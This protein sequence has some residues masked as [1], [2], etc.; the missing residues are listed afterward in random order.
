M[1]SKLTNPKKTQKKL[2]KYALKQI[3]GTNLNSYCD[4][5]L[6]DECPEINPKMY[7]A[8]HG[9]FFIYKDGEKNIIE[10]KGRRIWL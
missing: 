3:Y 4:K 10:A 6:S 5:G 9:I 2:R 8:V 1:L 7:S